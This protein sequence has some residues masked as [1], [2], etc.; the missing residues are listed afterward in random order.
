[1]AG[2]KDGLELAGIRYEPVTLHSNRNKALAAENLRKL[3]EMG[4]D[5]IYSLSSAG[6]KIAKK[7]K[8]RTPVIATV[9][10]HPEVLALI[11][12]MALQ[13]PS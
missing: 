13:V 9:V 11:K 2:I 5:L 10:N 8:L 4:L 12:I 3:V 7:T 1:M 6:T